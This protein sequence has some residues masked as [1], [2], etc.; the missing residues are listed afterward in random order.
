MFYRGLM[1]KYPEAKVILT[2]RDPESWYDSV[3]QTIHFARNTI[4]KWAV[5]LSPRMLGT[6]TGTQ[7]GDGNRDAASIDSIRL[8][9]RRFT[10]SHGQ[11][12]RHRVGWSTISTSPAD[13]HRAA[14]DR[15]ADDANPAGRDRDGPR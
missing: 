9:R 3:R 1:E 12:G 4:P 10:V 5:V 15:P 14:Q 7:L 8:E 13:T 2:V 11:S 6:E